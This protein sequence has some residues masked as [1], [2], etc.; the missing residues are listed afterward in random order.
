VVLYPRL[1]LP[2]ALELVNTQFAAGGQTCDGLDSTEQ[3]QQWLRVNAELFDVPLPPVTSN[4]LER[5]RTLRSALRALFGAAKEAHAPPPTALRLVNHVAAASPRFERLEFVRDTPS[6]TLVDV[7]D[8]PSATLAC[9]ARSAIEVL[10]GPDRGDVGRCE[11]PG[12]VLFFVKDS[13]RRHWC[14][15][16]CGNRARVARHYVRSRRRAQTRDDRNEAGASGPSA[17]TAS[18]D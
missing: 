17:R 13:R 12:C 10:A 3:L 1:G 11:A 14:S 9:V 15:A 4:L 5:F 18:A 7:A 2:L 8:A 16:A 6:M